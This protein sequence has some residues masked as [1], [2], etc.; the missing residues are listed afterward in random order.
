MSL[1][2]DQE[3]TLAL[4]PKLTGALGFCGSAIILWDIWGNRGKSNPMLRALFGMSVFYLFDAMAWFLSSWMAP[5]STGFAFA[6]GNISTCAFQGFWLQAVIAGPL[7]NTVMACFFNLVACH[8]SS[9][10]KL[11]R[12]EP[13]M[14][15]AVLFFALGTSIAFWMDNQYNHIGAVCWVNGSPP[16]CGSSTFTENPDVPCERG[17]HAWL[18]GMLMFYL[19]LWICILLQVYFNANIYFSVS[20]RDAK[21]VAQQYVCKGFACMDNKLETSH[22]LFLSFSEPCGTFW[23][24]VSLGRPRPFGVPSITRTAAA[25]GWT[26]RPPFVN[27]WPAFGIFLFS[28]PIDPICVAKSWA[29]SCVKAATTTLPRATIK[30]KSKAKT[31]HFPNKRA[32][33]PTQFA[34]EVTRATL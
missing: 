33:E 21:W 30:T 7:Y 18:Y 2:E 23:P 28:F 15:A 32:T 17:D 9:V 29:A 31:R 16:Q 6:I 4:V 3:V 8:G 19:P 34:R 26:W 27:L 5:S 12:L 11:R 24:F 1:T 13:F 14:H 20:E 25:F 22:T 10:E